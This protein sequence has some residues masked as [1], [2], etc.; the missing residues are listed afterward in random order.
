MFDAIVLA[1]GSA[2]RL[3]GADK[4]GLDVGGMSLLERV[5]AATSDAD[6]VVVV[7]AQRPLT[8]EVIWCRED[9]PGAGPVAAVA[10][11]LQRVRADVVL[12]LAA[13]LP[14]IAPAV[15]GLVAALAARTC[16]CAALVDDA[17]RVNHLAAAWRR[18]SLVRALTALGDPVG[19]SMRALVST[20]TVTR[21]PDVAGWGLDCDTWGDVRAA[22]DARN[23]LPRG[24]TTR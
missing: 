8:A 23:R 5:V 2:Q 19:A 22:R 9:P 7:G 16:D 24:A 3:G 11:G 13:D 18:A 6:R 15:P 4:P 17:G 1:G 10:A 12:T 14:W 21:V 20:A